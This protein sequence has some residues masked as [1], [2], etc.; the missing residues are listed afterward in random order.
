M[1]RL[2][3]IAKYQVPKGT[4][5]DQES[6]EYKC[7]EPNWQGCGVDIHQVQLELQFRIGNI[8]RSRTVGL[9][10]TSCKLGSLLR[11]SKSEFRFR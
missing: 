4:E 10:L 7:V 3:A 1:C 6:K 2:S 8:Y 9:H 11:T 5:K